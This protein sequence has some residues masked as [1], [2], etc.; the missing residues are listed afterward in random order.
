MTLIDQ[1]GSGVLILVY[2]KVK[3]NDKLPIV[4][5]YSIYF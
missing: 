1:A 3:S 5:Y 2:S 4:I